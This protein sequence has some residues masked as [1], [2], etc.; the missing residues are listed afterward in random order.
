MAKKHLILLGTHEYIR[1]YS[2]VYLGG[3]DAAP[4]L[5]SAD[6]LFAELKPSHSWTPSHAPQKHHRQRSSHVHQIVLFEDEMIVPDLGSNVG[7][8]LKWDGQEME[9][10]KGEMAR[11][12][13]RYDTSR[14]VDIY[15]LSRG[16][17]WPDKFGKP[18]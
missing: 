7:W 3:R 11:G 18:L 13:V 8:R 5:S 16:G 15:V 17:H 10:L 4:T 9:N 2:T 14:G 6:G 1:W 12:I